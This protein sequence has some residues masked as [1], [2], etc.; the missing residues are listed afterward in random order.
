MQHCLRVNDM[1]KDI[2][3]LEADNT[4][5]VEALIKV[6]NQIDE[7][8]K[9]LDSIDDLLEERTDSQVTDDDVKKLLKKYSGL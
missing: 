8:K 7:M 2:T 6:R 5:L 9:T 4:R 1:K 3:Q